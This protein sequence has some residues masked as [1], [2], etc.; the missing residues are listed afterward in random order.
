MSVC[1]KCLW[2]CVGVRAHFFVCDIIS[3]RTGRERDILCEKDNDK[4][5]SNASDKMA[6]LSFP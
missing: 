1:V 2:V 4:R 5:V 6:P 3:M